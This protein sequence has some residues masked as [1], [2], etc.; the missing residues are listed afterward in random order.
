MRGDES[1]MVR[2]WKRRGRTRERNFQLH[3]SLC[4]EASCDERVREGREGEIER[5]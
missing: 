5:G 3:L 1:E 2:A 4:E